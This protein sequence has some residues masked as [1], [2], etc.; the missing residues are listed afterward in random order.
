MPKQNSSRETQL[1]V[2]VTTSTGSNGGGGGG[3]GT[4]G[5]MVNKSAFQWLT[6]LLSNG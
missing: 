6:S 1:H 3:G 5:V 2:V 4:G